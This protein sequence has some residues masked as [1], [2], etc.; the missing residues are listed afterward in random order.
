MPIYFENSPIGIEKSATI[1]MTTFRTIRR[2]GGCS[3]PYNF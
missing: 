3:A 2:K 1:K